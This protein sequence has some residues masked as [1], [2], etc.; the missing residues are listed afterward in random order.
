MT[1]SWTISMTW[2]SK[3][4]PQP[5]HTNKSNRVSGDRI[6]FSIECSHILVFDFPR[7]KKREPNKTRS[8]FPFGYQRACCHADRMMARSHINSKQLI[9][10]TESSSLKFI[11]LLLFRMD[12]G[13]FVSFCFREG[14]SPAESNKGTSLRRVNIWLWLLFFSYL[15]IT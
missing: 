7:M 12:F 6:K 2:R 11:S 15:M 13:S 8:L 3:F 1:S 4:L 9:K 5:F 10:H 14:W